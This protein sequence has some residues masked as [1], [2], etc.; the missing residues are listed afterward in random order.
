MQN[1]SYNVS[2]PNSN[3]SSTVPCGSD[4]NANDLDRNIKIDETNFDVK[5]SRKIMH[6]AQDEKSN[7]YGKFLEPANDK[8]TKTLTWNG[9]FFPESVI[10]LVQRIVC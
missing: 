10:R 9:M 7:D 3:L 8:Y 1:I 2:E 5:V 4:S 6:T